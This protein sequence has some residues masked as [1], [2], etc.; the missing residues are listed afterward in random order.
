MNI[1]KNQDIESCIIRGAM[2][3]ECALAT[4]SVCLLYQA[5]VFANIASLE[6]AP[7]R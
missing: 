7:N 6:A 2:I 5:N 3:A 4:E 1:T